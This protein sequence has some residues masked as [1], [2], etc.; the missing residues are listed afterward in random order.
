MKPGSSIL[1]LAG[2]ALIGTN[3]VL[4]SP[5]PLLPTSSTTGDN[6]KNPVQGLYKRSP[7]KNGEDGISSSKSKF[8]YLSQYG[9]PPL[10][11][12]S[13]LVDD[14]NGSSTTSLGLISK[15]LVYGAVAISSVFASL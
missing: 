3:A 9:L 5:S 7:E 6:I 10:S 8:D 12:T 14:D 1:L 13:G 15:A 2:I 4:A 11:D